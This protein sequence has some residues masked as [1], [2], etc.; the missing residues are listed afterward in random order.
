MGRSSTLALLEIINGMLQRWSDKWIKSNGMESSRNELTPDAWY[1]VGRSRTMI[2]L[3]YHHIRLVVNNIALDTALSSPAPTPELVENIKRAL[4]SAVAVVTLHQEDYADL[5]ALL[6]CGTVRWPTKEAKR[7]EREGVG[8]WTW[9]I[10][11]CGRNT[12]ARCAL[13]HPP[14]AFQASGSPR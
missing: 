10:P 8:P 12:S 13:L 7:I 5:R 4:E 14:P 6:Y 11:V 9:L 2:T 3:Y 1:D